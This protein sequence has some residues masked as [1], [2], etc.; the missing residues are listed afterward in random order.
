MPAKRKAAATKAK[1]GKKAKVEEPAAPKTLK[2]ASAALK[3]EDKK[4]GGKKSHKVDSFVPGASYYSVG[5]LTGLYC[6]SVMYN[7]NTFCTFMII[8]KFYRLCGY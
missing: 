4:S 6:S 2:D 5:L 3:A 1:G 8:T 7:I